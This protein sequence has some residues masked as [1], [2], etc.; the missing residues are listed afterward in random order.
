MVFK[1]DS[2]HL[3]QKREVRG[4]DGK[5][6]GARHCAGVAWHSEVC[7]TLPAFSHGLLP[8]H[9]FPP[10]STVFLFVCFWFFSVGDVLSSALHTSCLLIS[11]FLLIRRQGSLSPNHRGGALSTGSGT[12]LPVSCPQSRETHSH[13]TAQSPGLLQTVCLGR[14][15]TAHPF[16]D[17]TGRGSVS[18]VALVKPLR[19]LHGEA[20]WKS[21][22]CHGS[23]SP[24]C[25]SP[26]QKSTAHWLTPAPVSTVEKLLV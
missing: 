4:I 18:E 3:K 11:L 6:I 7:L 20:C 25:E 23:R 2:Y 8:G 17:H 13:A 9:S 21:S 16:G 26:R 22:G 1:W 5:K 15:L 10:V 19:P 24:S 14:C 12:A